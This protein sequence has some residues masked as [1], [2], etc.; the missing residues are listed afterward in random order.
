MGLESNPVRELPE[1]LTTKLTTAISSRIF[2][3][4]CQMFKFLD[5]AKIIKPY[6]KNKDKK[7]TQA[8]P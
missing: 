3:E 1:A 5:E 7:F 4:F 6:R 8:S 2:N